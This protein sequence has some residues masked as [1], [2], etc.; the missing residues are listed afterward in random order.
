MP[1]NRTVL[2]LALLLASAMLLVYALVLYPQQ[3]GKALK[4]QEEARMMDALQEAAQHRLA[5]TRNAVKDLL[6]SGV[7]VYP[8][9][10]KAWGER[11]PE[12]IQG[13][14]E[15]VRRANVSLTRLEPEPAEVRLPLVVHPFVL[16]FTGSFSEVLV[17]L[18]GLERGL[19]FVPLQWSL[20][21]DPKA[22]RGLKG[23][24]KA[25]VYEWAGESLSPPVPDAGM[26]QAVRGSSSRDPFTKARDASVSAG[27]RSRPLALVLT[28]ILE[29]GGKRK[30]IINGKAHGVGDHVGGRRI[31]S[32]GPDEVEMDGEARPLRIERFPQLVAPSAGGEK[33]RKGAE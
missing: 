5:R 2:F 21:G 13:I 1:R 20:E 32:I 14:D 8:R 31:V 15:G 19:R 3:K 23:T 25:V 18:E 30:A 4:L 12:I 11:M 7:P 16:E 29:F 6:G 22:G 10:E 9:S 24:C 33:R 17:F 27:P 26:L 28:G